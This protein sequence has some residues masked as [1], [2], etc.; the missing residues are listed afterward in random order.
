ML[1]TALLSS[2]YDGR[3]P[4]RGYMPS[5][6]PHSYEPRSF[7]PTHF[8]I[9]REV[10]GRRPTADDVADES[11]H[12]GKLQNVGYEGNTFFGSESDNPSDGMDSVAERLTKARIAAGFRYAADA[13]RQYGWNPT[14]YQAHESGMRGVKAPRAREYAAAFGVSDGW[15]LTGKGEREGR[16]QVVKIVGYIGAGAELYAYTADE[17]WEGLGE[18]EAPPGA[19]PQSVAAVI[20]GDSNLPIYEEGEILVWSERRY[21]VDTFL[22]RP[23]PLIVHLADGRKLLKS[24][25]RGKKPRRYTLLSPNAAPIQDVEIESVSRIDWTRPRP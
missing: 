23:K 22:N 1:K 20:R 4:V 5:V 2:S 11:P 24:I 14:T 6:G 19:N 16:V 15:L 18:I 7:A 12:D 17:G 25:V 8:E 13:A 9:G 10:A 3:E 21:D